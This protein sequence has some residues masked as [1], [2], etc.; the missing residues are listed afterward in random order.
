MERKMKPEIRRAMTL[1]LAAAAA[2]VA[3]A[4]VVAQQAPVSAAPASPVTRTILHRADVPGSN[5]EVIYA[6]VE[7][8]AKTTVPPHTHPGSVFGYLLEGDYTMQIEGQPARTLQPGEWLQVPA[9][10]VHA[11]HSGDRPAR[12]LAVFTVEKGK[13]LTSSVP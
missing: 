7:V 9:H 4:G 1:I 13:P 5:Y 10:A 8:A 2:L 3:P 12:L 11:E 6:L